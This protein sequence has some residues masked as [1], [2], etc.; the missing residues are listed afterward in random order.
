MVLVAEGS[1]RGDGGADVVGVVAAVD[2]CGG[3]VGSVIGVMEDGLVVEAFSFCR[4]WVAR[5]RE[6][7]VRVFIEYMTG[8]WV[9]KEESEYLDWSAK[10]EVAGMDTRKRKEG[11]RKEEGG[12][13]GGVF[14]V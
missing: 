1:R 10:A 5:V 13:K 9:N 8:R 11:R 14:L 3:D 4:V 6:A 2:D 7:R 12:R